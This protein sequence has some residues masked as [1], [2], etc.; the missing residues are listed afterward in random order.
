MFERGDLV[1]IEIVGE[2]MRVKREIADVRI[3]HYVY[4]FPVELL[5]LQVEEEP[6]TLLIS[7][8]DGVGTEDKVGG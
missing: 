2:V 6:P 8:M 1:T 4:R 7:V 3:G 5:K